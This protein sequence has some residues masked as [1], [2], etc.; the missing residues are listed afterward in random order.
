M[1]LERLRTR[2]GDC[3]HSVKLKQAEVVA[4]KSTESCS[5]KAT[6]TDNCTLSCTTSDDQ[7]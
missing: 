5:R 7:L 4:R 1:E 6:V 2:Q 3:I